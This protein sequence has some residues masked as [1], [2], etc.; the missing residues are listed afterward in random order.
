MK[1]G[2]FVEGNDKI[3]YRDDLWH[4]EDGPAIEWGNGSLGWFQNG[5]YHRED[6]PAFIGSSSYGTKIES[7]WYRGERIHCRTQEEF[8]RLIRLRSFW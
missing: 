8:E 4:R 2:I 5:E 1:N 6:G 3:W 7:W